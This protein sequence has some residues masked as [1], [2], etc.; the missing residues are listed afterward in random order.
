MT[1]LRQRLPLLAA[2][3]L[4]PLSTLAQARDISWSGLQW[5]VK[6]SAGSTVGPGPNYFSDS[7]DNVWVDASGA[8]HLKITQNAQGQWQCAEIY[9]KQ[10]LGYGS[11]QFTL[12]SDVADLDPVM[13]LGLF[14]Y[15]DSP[16]YFHREIDIEFA[17]WSMAD[18]PNNA[19]YVIQPPRPGNIQQW[20]LPTGYASSV[21]QFTWSASK[22]AYKS[23]AGST[24]LQQWTAL[25]RE[26]IPPA[27]GERL[28][29]NLWLHQGQAP[30]RGLPTEIVISNFRYLP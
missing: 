29:L 7:S 30:M 4:C 27:G 11:Y 21:H 12:A 26:W 17:R 23:S 10:S 1:P 13:V 8:L 22:V 19:Q 14:T 2:L 18:N 25:R 15:A 3:L 6:S 16:Q 28:H 24:T 5:T 20:P 9:S